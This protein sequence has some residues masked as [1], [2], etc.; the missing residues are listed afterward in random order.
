MA[1]VAGK[2]DELLVE[3]R[4]VAAAERLCEALREDGGQATR[5]GRE[6]RVALPSTMRGLTL[7]LSRVE[8]A[9][10]DAEGCAVVR[11]DG[12]AYLIE[13]RTA[14]ELP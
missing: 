13:P 11:L 12:K 2:V 10:A 6:V 9:L 1:V 7:L 3:V 14:F 8:E 5:G 4:S